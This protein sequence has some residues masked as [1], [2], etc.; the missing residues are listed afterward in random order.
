MVA[1]NDAP[2]ADYRRHAG[3][4]NDG[5][6]LGIDVGGTKTAL[7]LWD[8]ATETVLVQDAFETPVEVGPEALVDEVW[9]ECERLLTG[10]ARSFADVRAVG[11][12]GA[13]THA[14]RCAAAEALVAGMLR[15]GVAI[16]VA[17]GPGAEATVRCVAAGG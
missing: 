14:D 11:A 1:H 3:E 12:A 17:L 9:Q 4:T 15:D 16:A 2:D 5:L 13:G 8:R 6:I 10:C 7:L